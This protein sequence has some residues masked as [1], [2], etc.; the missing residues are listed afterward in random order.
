M[1]I[2]NCSSK[3]RKRESDLDS[4]ITARRKIEL[5]ARCSVIQERAA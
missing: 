4:S 5:I 1:I 3:V 2:F